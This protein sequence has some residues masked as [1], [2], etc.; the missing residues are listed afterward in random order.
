MNLDRQEQKLHRLHA[1]VLA[2]EMTSENVSIFASHFLAWI[3]QFGYLRDLYTVP[4]VDTS[5]II[6]SV[7]VQLAVEVVVDS[8]CLFV[9]KKQG[10]HLEKIWKQMFNRSTM[11]ALVVLTVSAYTL[12][13]HA[14]QRASRYCTFTNDVNLPRLPL[15]FWLLM[16]IPA[17][18]R[19]KRWYDA[20]GRMEI[21]KQRLKAEES[22]RNLEIIREIPEEEEVEGEEKD[23]VELKNLD[24][25]S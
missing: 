7:L 24:L 21:E 22:N 25:Y 11:I 3:F 19:Y 4:R 10:I 18:Y 5:E 14:F 6:Q 12:A 15:F 1:I 8:I 13:M 9:E 2:L 16:I 23:R 17:Y 20:D